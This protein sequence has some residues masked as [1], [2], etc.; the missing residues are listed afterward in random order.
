MI[1]ALFP[2]GVTVVT[3]TQAMQHAPLHPLEA[4]ATGRMAEKRLR[5]FK[6][7]R[8]CVREGLAHLG[9]REFPFLND[10]D[11]APIWPPDIV[12]SLTH[13]RELCAAA[14]ARRGRIQGLGL[15]AESLRDLEPAIVER[16]ASPEERAH[17]ARL[18]AR[19]HA[20]GWPL[21]VFSAKE[22]FYKCYYP[23]ARTFLAFGD[24]EVEFDAEGA[25]FTARLLRDDAPSAAGTRSF[26]GRFVVSDTYIA[27]AVTL[28]GDERSGG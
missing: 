16:I 7:G 4:Q 1:E 6:L 12:G 11:R 3:A 20:G 5:E 15:D 2:N 13:C 9:V 28:Q 8:A 10:E 27:T 23:L 24:A 25:C 18:P 17:L 26:Q 21:L 14:M 19:R 22:A